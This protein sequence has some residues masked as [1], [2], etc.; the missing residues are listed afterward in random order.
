VEKDYQ[1][2]ITDVSKYYNNVQNIA[3]LYGT[4]NFDVLDPYMRGVR[5]GDN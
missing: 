3:K 2:Q 1:M 4:A 5:C